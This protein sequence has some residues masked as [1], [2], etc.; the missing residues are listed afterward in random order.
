M[1]KEIPIVFSAEAVCATL[2]NKKSQAR[3]LLSRIDQEALNFLS[4]E[5][6]KTLGITYAATGHGGP[7]WYAVSN[8][9]PDEGSHFLSSASAAVGD[10]LWVREAFVMER[11]EEGNRLIWKAD[12]AARW[13]DPQSE[14]YYLAST[15][16][17]ARGWVNPRL[18]PRWAARL[19]LEV[20][21]ARIERLHSIT[22]E[23][24]YAEGF[25]DRVLVGEAR[26]GSARYDFLR[27][28]HDTF[29]SSEGNPWVQVVDF[30][31]LHG[32]GK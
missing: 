30:K 24:A 22:E 20:T 26:E 28:W 12:R 31:V 2:E 13:K 19:L 18:M 4:G 32:G 15:Y 7:G 3:R 17:P 10:L 11:L 6:G 16:E 21:A 14:V 1:A 29:G 23:D 25:T 9:Y 5:D 8:D 27:Y